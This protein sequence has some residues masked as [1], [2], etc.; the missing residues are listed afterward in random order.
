MPFTANYTRLC[1]REHSIHCGIR[2]KGH[3]YVCDE[4]SMLKIPDDVSEKLFKVLIKS[5]SILEPLVTV[6]VQSN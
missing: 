6:I 1:C 2:T 5:A 4:L 3:N